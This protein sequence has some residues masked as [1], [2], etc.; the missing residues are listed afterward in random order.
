MKNSTPMR[1]TNYQLTQRFHFDAAHTLERDIETESSRRIHGHTYTAEIT[2]AG[3]PDA[4]GGMVMDLAYLRAI[5]DDVRLKL[6]HRL[7]NEVDGLVRPTLEGL[8]AFIWDQL[9]DPLPGLARVM[10][11]R[12]SSGAGGAVVR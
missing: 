4:P 12:E 3:T 11:G 1:P 7:L 2:I 10:V 5:V 6:D 8:C 9:A